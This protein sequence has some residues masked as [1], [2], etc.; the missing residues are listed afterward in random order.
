MTASIPPSRTALTIG[1]WS[2]IA[3]T[4][5]F[6]AVFTYLA[7]AFGYPDVL[8]QPA[9]E[10]LPRLLALGSSGRA[11]WVVYGLVPLLLIPTALGVD[12]AARTVAPRLTKLAVIAAVLSAVTM[13]AGLLRWP[14]LQWQ[15]ALAYEH[16]SPAAQESISAFFAA[17]NSYLG[18]YIGEFLGELFLNT[19]F[20][21]ASIVLARSAG[22]SRRWLLYAG[23]V[24]SLMGGI[25]MLRNVVSAVAPIASLNNMVLPVW[26]LVL[27]VAMITHRSRFTETPTA[28][29]R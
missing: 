6:A 24:A 17:A 5:L 23:S 18:N 14:S 19:F 29:E 2:I 27:G 11:V 28:T 21:C 16:A 1:G 22:P 4:V 15:L 9:A 26:M 7:G 20:L 10:V 25:A 8:D 13:M 12:A 3:A